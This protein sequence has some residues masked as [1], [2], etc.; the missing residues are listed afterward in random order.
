MKEYMPLIYIGSIIVI[1]LIVYKT[2]IKPIF[3]GNEEQYQ[4]KKT[5]ID[6]I[7]VEAALTTLTSNEASLI[8]NEIETELN[9]LNWFFDR[10]FWV[11]INSRVQTKYDVNLVIK[12]FG[13]RGG[14]TLPE[15]FNNEYAFSTNP[16]AVTVK[17]RF[18]IS[19]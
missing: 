1:L 18:K 4:V 10:A 17:N 11:D 15:W 2:L 7:P 5:I 16:E 19:S 9:G 6:N 13:I 14:Q 8:A 3:G 12:A